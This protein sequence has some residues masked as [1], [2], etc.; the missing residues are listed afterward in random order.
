MAG[1]LP[2]FRFL[3]FY[4]QGHGDGMIQSLVLG[5]TLTTIAILMF[6]AGIIVDLIA[7]NRR[8]LE[9]VLEKVKGLELEDGDV[10]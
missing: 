6:F 2:I 7:S 3:W 1:V 4:F 9:S 10:E 5:S 8:M